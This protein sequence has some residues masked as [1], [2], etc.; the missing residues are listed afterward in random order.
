M[1]TLINN[2]KRDIIS[3]KEE[4]ARIE[5]QIDEKHMNQIEDYKSYK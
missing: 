3:N 5:R 1:K 2:N 4:I